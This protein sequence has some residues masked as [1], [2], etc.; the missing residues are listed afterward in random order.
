M[1]PEPDPAPT[2]P[3]HTGAHPDRVG[4]PLLLVLASLAT[5]S[6]IA[7]DLYLPGFPD[8]ARDLHTS[9]SGV[10]LTLTAFLV[11][12]GVG[13]MVMGPLSDSYG[14]RQPLVWSTVGCVVGGVIAAMAPTLAILII[15]R[16]IQ[17]LAGAGGV[18]IGRAVLADLVTGR[19]AAK[20]F[21]LMLTVGGVAPV[22][23]PFVGS[24]L[25]APLGWRG[26]LW[27]LALLTLLMVP[28][29][30]LVVRE[31]HPPERRSQAG[32][33][34]R[35]L[36]EVV[37]TR[38]YWPPVAVFALCFGVLMTYIAASP[39]VYQNV[40]GL[41]PVGYGVAFAINASGMISSG[42]FASR[43]VDRIQPRQIVRIG[44][45]VQLI[46]NATL[47]ALTLIHAP[48][49]LIPVPIFFAVMCNGAIMGNA[50][51]LAM[52]QVRQ[53]AGAGSALLGGAQF[54]VGSVLSPLAGVGGDAS[55][56]APAL[57]MAGCSVTAFV[58]TRLGLRH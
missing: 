46:A 38:A 15:G 48:A 39:F 6:P 40:V 12:M 56:L 31:T 22:L 10:Q 35:T 17:G 50:A 1:T 51:S 25:L 47:L 58:V 33:Y 29:V 20:A 5:V 32:T 4:W 43:V 11:G 55:V 57:I 36:R 45:L 24:L 52:S 54:A 16:L 19:A 27:V 2:E 28:G 34:G 42:W 14:R 9:A 53:V 8:L 7:T 18:V 3:A 21:T 23:S 30:V 13:Q 41:S 26:L 49:W 37:A 44:V